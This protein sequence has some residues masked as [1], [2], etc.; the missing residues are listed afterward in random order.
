MLKIVLSIAAFAAGATAFG[1]PSPYAKNTQLNSTPGISSR[2]TL[3]G[4]SQDPEKVWVL[5]PNAGEVQ[6]KGFNATA[7]IGLCAAVK[8]VTKR[9]DSL[10]AK[11]EQ[12]D[13][14]IK[15]EE[16]ELARLNRVVEE[17]RTALAKELENPYVKEI[18]A[19]E[20][21]RAILDVTID[22]LIDKLSKSEDPEQIKVIRTQIADYRTEKRDL[23]VKLAELKAN[24]NV[25]YQKY[26]VAK[27]ELD[28]A[29]ENLNTHNDYLLDLH[30]KYERLLSSVN[31]RFKKYVKTE[32]GFAHI[33]YD[34]RWQQEIADLQANYSE[35]RFSPIPT[36]N[37]RVIAEF[38]KDSDAESY[39]ESMPSLLGYNVNGKGQ[40]PYGTH[41]EKDD[42]ERSKHS[43]PEV[44]TIDLR[45]N[46]IGACPMADKDFYKDLNYEVKR[47][48]NGVPMFGIST[49]YE[50]DVAFKYDVQAEYNLWSFYEKIVRKGTRGGFFSSKS[51]VEVLEDSDDS[52]FFNFDFISETPVDP[53]EI[54]RI[55]TEIKAD[56]MNR[57][58]T[59]IAQPKSTSTRDGVPKPSNPPAPGTVVIANGLN[60]ICGVNIYCQ[61]GGWI[62]RVAGSI[63]GSS[64]TETRIRQTWNKSAKENWSHTVMKPKQ[65]IVTYR[66]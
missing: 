25:A 46:L 31:E 9:V 1:L 24:N 33:D 27:Q 58:L 52:S 54:A 44:V 66:R 7:N 23:V 6:F 20:E 28:A 39:F 57:V 14:R 34:S 48:R 59:T 40:L 41:F 45:L 61:V 16:V 65:A 11:M 50:F 13:E 62:F 53:N 38:I 60:K 36:Y 30:D 43:F 10:E 51:Y 42:P 4:D 49:V 29:K 26:K 15:A 18:S 55:R 19:L 37:S 32:G 8:R 47:D 64:K 63:W 12:I 35:L 17:K 22:Q 56:L 21:R 2:S 3:I 5:P